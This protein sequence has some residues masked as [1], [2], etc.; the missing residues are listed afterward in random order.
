GPGSGWSIWGTRHGG[1]RRVKIK[2][3]VAAGAVAAVAVLMPTADFA[4]SC[5]NV[6]RKAPACFLDCPTPIVNGNWV[7]LA[8]LD[9]IVGEELPPI[10]AFLPPGAPD[11]Q[12]LQTPGA[13]GNYTNG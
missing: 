11:S 3:L 9:A 5:A 2:H 13:N 7:W 10:W 6:S 1:N 8:S 4:D 12:F